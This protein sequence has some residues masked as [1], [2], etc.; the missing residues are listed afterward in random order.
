MK[1]QVQYKSKERTKD[2]PFRETINLLE[3]QLFGWKSRTTNGSN[4]NSL[5][6]EKPI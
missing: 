2:K 5:L 4:L 1:F 6:I 3:K